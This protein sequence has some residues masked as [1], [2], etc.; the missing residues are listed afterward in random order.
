MKKIRTLDLPSVKIINRTDGIVYTF[1]I[2]CFFHR[3]I[4]NEVILGHYYWIQ[5]LLSASLWTCVR[6]KQAKL[7]NYFIVFYNKLWQR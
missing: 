5:F 3:V 2:L 1:M 6:L 4:V 7:N